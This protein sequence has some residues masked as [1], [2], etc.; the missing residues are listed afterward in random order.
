M[1]HVRDICSVQ[2]SDWSSTYCLND[3]VDEFLGF[4]NLLLSI[5][6]NETMEVLVLVA[7]VSGVRLPFALFDRAFAAN[8][9]FGTGLL[10]HLF[11]RVT[12]RTNEQAD[13]S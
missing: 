9:D 8:G 6:H 1:S 10:F 5:A 13:C 2:N 3:V 4:V 7:G 12:T 11:Q